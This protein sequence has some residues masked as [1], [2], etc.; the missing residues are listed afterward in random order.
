MKSSLRGRAGATIAPGGRGGDARAFNTLQLTAESRAVLRGEVKVE[1]R[2]SVFGPGQSQNQKI[3]GPGSGRHQ[4]PYCACNGAGLSVMLPGPGV[5]PSWP[6]EHNLPAYA[7]FHYVTLVAIAKR[8][9]HK[10]DD[11]QGISGIGAKTRKPTQTRCCG[12]VAAL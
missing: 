3:R 10:L 4:G 7:I 2:E 6:K 5:S 8:A 12:V 1:L 11:L 9:P